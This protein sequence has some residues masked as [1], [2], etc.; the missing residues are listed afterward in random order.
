[1]PTPGS[2]AEAG[3][4]VL[5]LEVSRGRHFPRTRETGAR[6][7]VRCQCTG[8]E[9]ASRQA[10]GTDSPFWGDIFSWQ[11]S[12]QLLKQLQT[13]SL[14]VN[15]HTHDTTSGLE[16]PLGHCVLHLKGVSAARTGEQQHHTRSPCR[17][18]ARRCST[19]CRCRRG[20]R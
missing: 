18:V 4:A 3:S 10:P 7:V 15:V 16:R 20:T 6:F 19:R 12:P 17:L 11:V 1:M 5:V 8:L 9:R 14:K 2:E 13:Q